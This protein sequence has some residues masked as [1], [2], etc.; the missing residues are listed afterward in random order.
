MMPL[1][2]RRDNDAHEDTMSQLILLPCLDSAEW[3]ARCRAF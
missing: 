3:A 1:G 2:N